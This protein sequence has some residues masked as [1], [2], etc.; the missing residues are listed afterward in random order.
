MIKTTPKRHLRFRRLAKNR[1]GMALLMVLVTIAILSAV[2]VDFVYQTRI[3]VRIAGNVRDRLKAYYLARSAVNL[4]RL[5]LHFQGQ[6]DKFTGGMLKLYQIIPIESDLAKA[7]TSGE[8]GEAFGLEGLNLGTTRGFGEF[9]GNFFSEIRDEYE[10]INLNS[11]ES[12]TSIAAPVSA[13]ILALIGGPRYETMFEGP[14]ADGQYNT[15]ADI[16][17]ALHDWIDADTT[18]DTFNPDVLILDPFSQATLFMPGTSGE[19]SRYDMLKDPYQNKNDPFFSVDELYMIRGV[20]D[21]FM[22]EFGEKFTVYTDPALL[23]NL[24]SVNDP[25]MMLSLLCMQPENLALCTEQGLP[26]LLEV[27]AL[28]FE[29]RNLM[30]MTTFMVPNNEAIQGFFNSMGPTLSPYFMKNL[31]PFSDTF[32]IRA[33]GQVGEVMVTIK[34]VVKNTVSGQEILYWREM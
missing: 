27:L 4:S 11:L 9:D 10:K 28:F 13:Q 8:M 25:V 19:D 18:F 24:T 32:S 21:D 5:V 29:F 20:N 23:L 15:P 3:N 2:I 33:V 16:V 22:E 6:V 12:I 26:Q 7:M 14:D 30:Q 31:A 1:S 34:T 17:V